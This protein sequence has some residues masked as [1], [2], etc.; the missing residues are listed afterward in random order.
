MTR[1]LRT[2]DLF[3]GIGGFALGLERSGGFEMVAFCEIE[4]Y[5]RRVL[6]KHWP[7]VPCYEDIR[8]LTVDT[9]ARDGI[10]VDAI[11]G[12][13]PCQDV[14]H[15][16]ARIG[17]EGERSGLWSE[18]RRLIGELRPRLV[19]VENVAGLLS[20]GLGNVLGDLA[21]LGY[22]STWDCIPAQAVGAPHRR[23][24]VWIVAYAN[25]HGEHVGAEHAEVA[26]PSEYVA[27]A[28]GERNEPDGIAREL[29]RKSG[30]AQ[31]QGRKRQRRGNAANGCGEDVADA[32]IEPRHQGRKGNASQGLG[33]RNADRSGVAADV[34]DA[35]VEGLAI[36]PCQ[37]L[38]VGVEQP[39]SLGSGH[40]S[41]A[42]RDAER[43]PKSGLGRIVDGLPQGLDR[44]D[45]LNAWPPGWEDGTPRVA[46][47]V[48]KRV[49][50]L[51]ALGNAVVPQVVELIA[52]S[53]MQSDLWREIE[54]QQ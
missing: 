40:S 28:S 1:R 34:P 33:R 19:I 42:G 47:G 30:S 26:E 4:P 25:G 51:A 16:G 48:P 22:S 23:D 31:S 15:A 24:R 36:G 43:Q 2:L 5:C 46:D 37:S 27:D 53:L 10:A 18:Y 8:Q 45:G 11:C 50:R 52:R 38:D 41:G 9:L 29:F 44:F 7:T 17:L 39:T 21:A 35:N 12:G 20:L 3:S 13:F 32:D 6:A 54:R 49:A 14:S